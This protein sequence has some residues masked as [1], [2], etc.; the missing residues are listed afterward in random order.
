VAPYQSVDRFGQ[1]REG[2][3]EAPG[4]LER[5]G[6][7]RYL[8]AAPAEPTAEMRKPAAG[9]RLFGQTALPGDR[10]E[11]KAEAG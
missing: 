6:G 9:R 2:R 8:E 4:D 1:L 7:V 10:Q 11:G 5:R 3:L